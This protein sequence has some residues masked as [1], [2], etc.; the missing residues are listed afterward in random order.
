MRPALEGAEGDLVEP[1]P[2]S[3]EAGPKGAERDEGRT[4]DP[5]RTTERDRPNNKDRNPRG[6]QEVR[7]DPRKIWEVGWGER[8]GE[9]DNVSGHGTGE[10]CDWRA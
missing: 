3:D 7:T 4:Q 10:L 9:K 2:T 8:D 6:P 5:E 1:T